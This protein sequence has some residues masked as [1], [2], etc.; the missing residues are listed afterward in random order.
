MAEGV[1]DDISHQGQCTLFREEGVTS[2][3]ETWKA[4]HRPALRGEEGPDR[5]P[6]YAIADREVA[7]GA[8]DPEVVFCLDDEFGP[9]NLSHN[10]DGSGP[11][12]AARAPATKSSHHNGANVA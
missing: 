1:V 11:R 2:A 3:P 10:Q 9:L 12:S 5:E 4:S 8:D 6:I 7:P